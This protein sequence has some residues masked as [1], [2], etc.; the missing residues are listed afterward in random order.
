MHPAEES[1]IRAFIAPHRR[2]RWLMSL[3]SAKRRQRFLDCLNHCADLDPRYARP[4]PSNANVVGLLQSYGAPQ[5]CYVLSN[6][7][8]LDGREMPLDEAVEGAAMGGWGTIISCIPGRLAYYYD[9][10]GARRFLLV[11]PET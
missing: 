7:A 5:T 4:L 6:T 3:G 2:P 8:A 11:R 1:T 9:E 10:C